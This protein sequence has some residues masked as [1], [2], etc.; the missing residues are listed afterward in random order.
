MFRPV[1]HMVLHFAVPLV[2]ARLCWSEHRVRAW[3]LML[4]AFAIDL[5]HLLATPIF[6]PMR[7]SLGFHPL[8]GWLAAAAYA[9]LLLPPKTRIIG[10]GLCLHLIL[11]GIDCLWMS[12]CAA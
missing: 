4:A 6:D 3:L 10:F 12:A 11:D 1:V 5:D 8:H 2:A 9:V 7:C